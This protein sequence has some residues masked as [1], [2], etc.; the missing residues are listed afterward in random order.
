MIR[1]ATALLIFA[2]LFSLKPGEA[3]P[4]NSTIGPYR[5]LF[6]G[7]YSGE[8]M[9]VVT[10]NNVMIRGNLL[11]ENGNRVNFVAPSLALDGSHF[12]DEVTIAGRKIKVTGRVDPSGG[13][14]LKARLVCT[15]SVAGVG[16]GRVAGDHK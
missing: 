7:C 2:A 1:R 12:H 9:G 8:G 10:A 6:R 13:P 5:L 15:F 4:P 14:L 11:D 3:A 16:H